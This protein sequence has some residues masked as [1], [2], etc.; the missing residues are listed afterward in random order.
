MQSDQ[1]VMGFLNGNGRQAFA[2]NLD[3]NL[4]TTNARGVVTFYDKYDGQW[5]TGFSLKNGNVGF[6]TAAPTQKI[7]VAG[8]LK[9]TGTGNGI[10]FADGTKQ[11]SAAGGV[12]GSNVW[13]GANVFNVGLSA[14]PSTRATP[15]T[16]LTSTPTQSSSSPARS[17]FRSA[18]PTAPRR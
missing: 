3:Y 5:H 7:E 14:T 15:R 2:I 12:S 4:G 9:V 18:T 13:T 16:R 17:S 8:N 6:G 1:T 11:T 10:I